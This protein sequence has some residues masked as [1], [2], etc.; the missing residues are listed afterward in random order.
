[1]GKGLDIADVYR[2][3][4]IVR[5]V[6]KFLS[7]QHFPCFE[8]LQLGIEK[9][10]LTIRGHVGTYY[11]KQVALTTCQQVPGVLQLVDRIDVHEP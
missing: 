3:E 9:G 2:D 4:D 1:M 5:R 7:L 8:R 10:S 6:S 11:E